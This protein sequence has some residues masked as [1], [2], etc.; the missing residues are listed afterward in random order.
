MARIKVAKV[1]ASIKRMSKRELY[2]TVCYYYPQYKLEDA[3]ALPG[4]D[5]ILLIKT[6]NKREAAKMYNFTSIAA[7]PHSK[8]MSQVKKLLNHFGNLAK[9]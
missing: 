5:L 4:R 3:Q 2:A 1:E 8:D 9:D 7:A 6:A